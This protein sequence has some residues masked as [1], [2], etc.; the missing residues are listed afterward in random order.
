MAQDWFDIPVPMTG[1]KV[2][3]RGKGLVRVRVRVC[4]PEP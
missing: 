3:I 1:I 2:S 4:E